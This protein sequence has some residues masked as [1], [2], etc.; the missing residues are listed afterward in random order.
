MTTGAAT[1]GGDRW[2]VRGKVVGVNEGGMDVVPWFTLRRGI[3]FNRGGLGKRKGLTGMFFRSEGA[4]PIEKGVIA[5]RQGSLG[6]VGGIVVSSYKGRA[7]IN[8]KRKIL[9]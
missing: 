9:F 8:V 6:L 7:L 3:R 1:Q 4:L 2:V 5:G